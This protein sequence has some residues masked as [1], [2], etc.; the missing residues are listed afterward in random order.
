MAYQVEQP[1]RVDKPEG[2]KSFAVTAL[3]SYILGYLGIDR[4]YLGKT[5]TG[6]LKLVTAG[7]AG[8]WWIIDI[9]ITLMG[10]QRD[11]RG[12][13]LYGYEEHKKTAR[14][15]IG[16]SFAIGVAVS[17]LAGAIGASFDGDGVT[18]VGWG[19]L[20]LF[21]AGAVALGVFLAR[22]RWLREAPERARRRADPVPSRVRAHLDRLAVL[23]PAYLARSADAAASA[24]IID[25]IDSLTSH[26]AELFR[27]LDAKADRSQRRLAEIEYDDKLRRV[28]AALDHDYL[29]DVLANP[30]LWD[31]PEQQ[32]RDV[33]DAVNAVDGQLLDNIKQVNAHRALVFQVGLDGLMGA[34]KA[35]TDWQRDFDEASGRE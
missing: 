30:R 3:L 4:F 15:L 18:P 19:L 29:L 31:S 8:L 23:R 16:G 22:R 32:V 25:S 21:S 26:T 20:G 10:A 7:G 17:I 13:R 24:G 34:R 33:Q 12:F 5:S 27:R 35:I 14:V 6:I 1:G 2:D 11:V 28:A 9:L